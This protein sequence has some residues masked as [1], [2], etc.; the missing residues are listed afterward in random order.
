M[1]VTLVGATV[2]MYSGDL[3]DKVY[4]GFK[5]L[6]GGY[7][8]GEKSYPPPLLK[9]FSGSTTKTGSYITAKYKKE[10][11]GR[12][13]EVGS[14]SQIHHRSFNNDHLAGNG[15]R[16]NVVY[17]EEVG[18]MG[19]LG[20]SLGAL[21]Q[22][23]MN[24]DVKFGTVWCQGTG[25]ESNKMV[26][27]S[28]KEVYFNPE[29]YD[30]VVFPN[31]KG[32]SRGY[33]V[34]YH[35]GMNGFK[36]S[37][38]NTN[39]PKAKEFVAK[40]REK[41]KKLPNKEQYYSEIQNNP[42]TPEEVFLVEEGNFFPVMELTEQ[43][44]FVENTEDPMIK[45]HIGTLV[46]DNNSTYGV[47]FVKDMYNEIQLAGFPV[48][49]GEHCH[50]GVHIIEFP[51]KGKIPYGMYVA[52]TDPYDQDQASNSN[53][54]GSTF[55]YKIGDFREGG[56]RDLIV[57]E[58]TGR[59]NT[60]EEHHEIVRRLLLF[61]NAEDLYENEKVTLK[62]HFQTKNSLHLL[63][64]QP[65]ILKATANTSVHRGYGIHMTKH[66][67]DEVS[68]YL[69]DWLMQDRGEGLKNYHF[70]YFP[71]LLK[72]LISYYD[73]GNFDRIIAMLLVIVQRMSHYRTKIE[74]KEKVVPF[75]GF[76][77]ERLF[78]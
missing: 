61:Y 1:S 37:E 27:E 30:M 11:G 66:I 46:L 4:L 65:N 45:G 15:L 24:G 18:F 19:N 7:K 53:S 23:T 55:I 57:A 31:E 12:W 35:L 60:A 41:L 2:S 34:P 64:R 32:G 3:L 75:N 26:V 54:L 70:V 52:G 78:E 5:H 38:G 47:K 22:T 69:R 62:F 6:E 8:T 9:K 17:L 36:D 56:M 10:V 42:E 50:G 33:F 68:L 49:K 39:V 67:K 25:G 14:G 58:Y 76:F 73:G 59:P 29:A 13:T 51:P 63:A 71:G 77:E 44:Q 74:N 43:L 16:T 20:A 48:K 21:K 40:V 28:V 72:E